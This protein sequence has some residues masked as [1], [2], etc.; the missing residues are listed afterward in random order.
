MYLKSERIIANVDGVRF[1]SFQTALP[2]FV[3][4]PIAV[5]GW[6]DGVDVRRDITNR[7]TSWG[8]F[9][10]GG[11]MAA[12]LVS[13]NGTAIAKTPRQLGEMRDKFMAIYNDGGFR[14][15]SLEDSSGVRYLNAGLEGQPIWLR[16]SDTVASWRIA[17]YAPDPR[18][19]GPKHEETLGDGGSSGGLNYPLTY[20]LDYNTEQDSDVEAKVMSNAGNTPAW[21]VF[22]VTGNYSAGFTI[23]NGK[24]QQVEYTGMVTTQAPV[25]IDMAKGTATQ[26][27][28]DKTILVRKRQWFSIPAKGSIRPEFK[29]TLSGTGWC[30]IIYRD[31]WI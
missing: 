18:I 7:P 30:G 25:T 3:L 16:Q 21:P 14:E 17:L 24:G 5:S 26:S 20:P 8:D 22:K 31:T 13:F 15:M 23:S 11:R 29:A 19:F 2:Q 9:S 4:D 6:Y 1:T 12:R 10:E 28:V 27:G